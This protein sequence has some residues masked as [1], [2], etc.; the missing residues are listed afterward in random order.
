M[1]TEINSAFFNAMQQSTD[2]TRTEGMQ[3]RMKPT[4]NAT[5]NATTESVTVTSTSPSRGTPGITG[6]TVF[7]TEGTTP[8]FNSAT[9]TFDQVTVLTRL[10]GGASFTKVHATIDLTTTINVSGT[11]VDL[12]SAK[13][14]F[15]QPG[16]A[17]MADISYTT[18]ADPGTITMDSTG[19]YITQHSISGAEYQTSG[20]AKIQG[21]K[22]L[23]TTTTNTQ[24][25]TF[26]VTGARFRVPSDSTGTTATMKTVATGGISPTTV[27][28]QDQAEL[29]VTKYEITTT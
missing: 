26:T 23:T 9:G 13:V 27:Q 22:G 6:S 14:S 3:Y 7:Y 28:W 11:D 12:T 16:A 24:G 19:G 5:V 2:L 29:A 4:T 15:T 8:R 20:G 21:I 1:P 25:T 10:T 17:V 18:N